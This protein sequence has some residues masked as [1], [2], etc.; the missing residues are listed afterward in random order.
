MAIFSRA[1]NFGT[2]LDGEHRPWAR[3]NKERARAAPAEEV[4]LPSSAQEAESER[5]CGSRC[6]L[7][8]AGWRPLPLKGNKKQKPREGS[9]RRAAEG[10]PPAGER[11]ARRLSSFAPPLTHSS[12][13]RPLLHWSSQ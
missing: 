13:R 6:F 12:S 3:R 11:G 5:K 1:P 2:T 7:V 10:E 8:E 9:E 4:F